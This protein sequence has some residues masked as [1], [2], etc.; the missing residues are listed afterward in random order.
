MFFGAAE[1]NTSA[2]APLLICCAS[3]ELA[4]KLSLTVT[5]GWAASNIFPIVVN[6]SVNDAA[7]R[8]VTVPDSPLNDL[9]LPPPPAA[10][11]V[12]LVEDELHADAARVVSATMATAVRRMAAPRCVNVAPVIT[13]HRGSRRRRS[14]P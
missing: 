8:T 2:G 14:S 1:A 9:A 4:P 10:A 7:A 11:D 6:D 12:V 5:P 3:V 13:T